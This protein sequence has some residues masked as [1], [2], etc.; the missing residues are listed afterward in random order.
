MSYEEIKESIEQI[1]MS[2]RIEE[3][4][5]TACHETREAIVHLKQAQDMLDNR[6]KKMTPTSGEDTGNDS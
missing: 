2:L 1:L 4:T 3:V 6:E 5:G